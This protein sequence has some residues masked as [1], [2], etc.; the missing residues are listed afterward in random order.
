LLTVQVR[1]EADAQA[2]EPAPAVQNVA[3]RHAEV[4]GLSGDEEAVASADPNDPAAQPFV[5]H[6][7]KLG[8]N[9]PC[10]CGSGKKYKHCHGALD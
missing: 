7:P 5:R 4:D 2:V 3:Y 6:G 1:S 8:R 10:W 9:D